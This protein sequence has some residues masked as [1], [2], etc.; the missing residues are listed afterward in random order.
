MT[1]EQVRILE[2]FFAHYLWLCDVFCVKPE[3]HPE[4]VAMQNLL[5][6]EK[7]IANAAPNNEH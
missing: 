3:R 6:Q 1:P 7:E 2:A 5:T 4:Y